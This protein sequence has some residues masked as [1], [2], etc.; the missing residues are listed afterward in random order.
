MIKVYDRDSGSRILSQIVIPQSEQELID[1]PQAADLTGKYPVAGHTGG[2]QR[3]EQ[4]QSP[5][6][7]S[8]RKKKKKEVTTF[9]KMKIIVKSTKT[10]SFDEYNEDSESDE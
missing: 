10:I 8:S 9:P 6:P 7:L 1:L 4:L 3:P 5:E 2:S